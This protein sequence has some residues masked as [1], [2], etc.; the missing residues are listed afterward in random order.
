MYTFSLMMGMQNIINQNFYMTEQLPT[1]SS[2][3]VITHTLEYA[4]QN[5][6]GEKSI[7]ALIAYYAHISTEY[8]EQKAVGL[9]DGQKRA[10]INELRIQAS[11]AVIYMQYLEST[12]VEEPINE[13]F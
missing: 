8:I 1:Y 6:I 4:Q 12:G 2:E 13:D 10:I 5:Y 9:S 7:P 3:D 11:R